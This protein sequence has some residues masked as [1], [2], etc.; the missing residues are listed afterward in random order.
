MGSA[1]KFF[2]NSIRKIV[3]DIINLNFVRVGLMFHVESTRSFSFFSRHNNKTYGKRLLYYRVYNG[4]NLGNLLLT[5]LFPMMGKI[6]PQS[7]GGQVAAQ[8]SHM[9]AQYFPECCLYKMSGR[10]IFVY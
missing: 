2:A 3:S 8:L 5:Y 10:M 9:V 6:E 7:F 4:L 1:A